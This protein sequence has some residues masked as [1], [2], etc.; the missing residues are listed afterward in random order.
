[1]KSL[2]LCPGD[3]FYWKGINAK[4][5]KLVKRLGL[6]IGPNASFDAQVLWDT[7]ELDVSWIADSNGRLSGISVEKI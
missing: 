2:K 3:I 4:N 5:G 1:M 7:G 6:Y